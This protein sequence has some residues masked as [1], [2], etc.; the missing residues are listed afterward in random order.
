MGHDL[1]ENSSFAPKGSSIRRKMEDDTAAM[2]HYADV[3]CSVRSTSERASALDPKDTL[4][5]DARV[6][7][8]LIFVL[9]CLVAERVG[10]DGPR[11]LPTRY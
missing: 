7:L 11:R 1:R 6:F 8:F 4:I 2:E 10:A 3:R 9:C 5:A